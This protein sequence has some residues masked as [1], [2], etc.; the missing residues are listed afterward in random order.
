M[1][2][3]LF[4]FFSHLV[5]I[6]E[7]RSQEI[8][9]KNPV[10]PCQCDPGLG[11]PPICDRLSCGNLFQNATTR[12]NFNLSLAAPGNIDKGCYQQCS[13]GF[14]GINCNICQNDSIC[15]AAFSNQSSTPALLSPAS[16]ISSSLICS[17]D[18]I[19]YTANFGQCSLNNQIIQNLLP[20]SLIVSIQQYPDPSSAPLPNL[21]LKD[22]PANSTTLQL[23]YSQNSSIP[24]IQQFTCIAQNCS[25]KIQN[26]IHSTTCPNIKCNCIPG[27]TLC[28]N[29]PFDLSSP[30]NSLNGLVQFI[31]PLNNSS[32]NSNSCSVIIDPLKNLLGP[33]GLSLSNCQFAECIQK[34]LADSK[35]LNL[36]ENLQSNHLNLTTILALII[37]ALILITLISL[38]SLGFYHQLQ[39]KKL[40][41]H[42]HH[43][44]QSPAKVQ[45][46]N[47]SYSLNI[48][49][50]SK[51]KSFLHFITQ[52]LHL[53]LFNQFNNQIHHQILHSLSGSV[54]P[55]S[56][57]A[58]LGPSGA[59]KSTLLDI[60]AGQ[61]KSGSIS[62]TR[63]LSV[64][65]D[66]INPIIIGF[67]HQSDILPATSTV[68]EALTF[69]AKLKLPES[70]S[71]DSINKLVS[72]LIE[73]LN[74]SQVANS[75]I[76]NDEIRGLSG[77]ERR[78]LSI[79]LELISKPSVIFLDEPTSGLDSVSAVKIIKL[80][81]D[82]TSSSHQHHGTT[83]ICSIH[84]PNSQIYHEFDYI[85]L[86]ASGG[87]QV[88]CGPT[89]D[90]LPFLQSHGLECPTGF[91]PADFL[92]QVASDLPISL[93]SNDN[94]EKQVKFNSKDKDP[95]ANLSSL[96]NQ[97]SISTST[98]PIATKLTQFQVICQREWQSLKRD[99]SLFWLHNATAV[100]VGI[101]VGT[102][103]F[104][105]N[106][107]ISGFQNRVGS[108]FFLG[109]IIVFSSLSALTNF[110]SVRV[111]F[112]RERAAN[113][114][115]SE[116][117][118]LARACFDIIPLRVLP[119]IIMCTIAY[120]MVGLKNDSI[121]Y[122][123]FLL[124]VIELALVQTI[125]HLWLAASMRNSAKAILISSFVNL[126]QLAF[127]GFF[128]NLASISKAISWI[129]FII[130]LKY[131]LEAMSVNEVGDGLMID[132]TVQGVKLK[133]SA[134]LIMKMLFGFKE[135]AYWRDSIILFVMCIFFLAC[136]IITVHC[137]LRQI[138]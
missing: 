60:L 109:A 77:G 91:N 102:L 87:R 46:L 47:L 61:H 78:R 81:K 18:K 56:M 32:S 76:G 31:C 126:C 26:N 80:L 88:Y 41:H 112:M 5:L 135:N 36:V 113:L 21:G 29:G 114:Y 27:T 2:S 63:H 73:L 17:Q 120:L 130:P 64:D 66:S 52:K 71:T 93:Q 119:C 42:S 55:A 34:S 11:N 92:L 123:K 106:T 22:F 129:Q 95:L 7:F 53:N 57:M 124:I 54:N 15:Q 23:F 3:K 79:G 82:L 97:I 44:N 84:Q 103:Y 111:L 14:T 121:H 104:Q 85:C 133:V 127:A 110:V 72:D 136:L 13:S 9:S 122:F 107:T 116:I 75:K 58:I 6:A 96:Q 67:V 50:N 99:T 86:L 10:S 89:S 35:R 100:L 43:L 83:V 1:K 69:S 30:L 40:N 74:L 138:H 98:K 51:F 134:L 45:W 94:Y 132:D 68:R 49:S 117:W 108:L 12:T 62:G 48:K 20:G 131:S 125:F 38:I 24:L 101:F 8:C 37:L 137:K 25:Q 118:L 115:A 4:S 105:V 90:A 19:P 16:T 128:A 28:G 39:A 65:N 59:G 33:Q 70:F